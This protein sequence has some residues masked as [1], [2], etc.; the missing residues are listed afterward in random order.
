MKQADYLFPTAYRSLN[1]GETIRLYGPENRFRKHFEQTSEAER[2]RIFNQIVDAVHDNGKGLTEIIYHDNSGSVI[3]TFLT[4]AEIKHLQDVAK[5]FNVGKYL[6][7]FSLACPLL[8]CYLKKTHTPIPKLK[9]VLLSALGGI[10]GLTVLV[11]VAGPTRIFYAIHELVFPPQH[12]WFFYYQDSLMTTLMQAPNLFGF[13]GAVIGVLST[14][15]L[16]ALIAGSY[17]FFK[18]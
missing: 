3:D 17:S 1:I 11:L 18:R 8:L 15:L 16:C 4:A 14:L 6:G 5:L 2:F 13:I 12:Q 10:A 7:W 9:H